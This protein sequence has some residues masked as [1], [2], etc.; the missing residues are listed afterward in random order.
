[1]PWSITTFQDPVT[2]TIMALTRFHNTCLITLALITTYVGVSPLKHLF[3]P[4]YFISFNEN[5]E[6]ELTWTVLPSLILIMLAIPSLRLLYLI[7]ETVF[8]HLT[9]KIIAHQ[10]YWSYDYITKKL[11]E[12]DSFIL[13]T[14]QLTQGD[15]RLLEVDNRIVIPWGVETRLLLSSADVLHAWAMPS[16]GVKADAIPGRLNQITIIPLKPG[17]FYGQCSE[18]C[19]ANHSFMPISIEILPHPLWIKWASAI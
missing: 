4:Y 1:M 9:V 11:L 18:I 19:G 3:S 6:I 14:N 7:E 2:P 16:R 5:H 13:P 10:W 12:F 8:P 15:L 17:V